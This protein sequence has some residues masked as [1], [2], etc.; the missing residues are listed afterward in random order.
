[1]FSTYREMKRLSCVTC[2][3]CQ[4]KWYTKK[5]VHKSDKYC[6]S[7]TE[8]A[9]HLELIHS[10]P[11]GISFQCNTNNTIVCQASTSFLWKHQRWRFPDRFPSTDFGAD[12]TERQKRDEKDITWLD[13]VPATLRSWIDLRLCCPFPAG[14]K[15]KQKQTS[16]IYSEQN[17]KGATVAE[18]LGICTNP[19]RQSERGRERDSCRILTQNMLASTKSTS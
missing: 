3:L 14:K 9:S 15:T 19:Q 2:V 5:C 4:I 10:Y 8:N 1:M 12:F 16:E 7:Y 17:K 18:E 11:H 13:S 6:I